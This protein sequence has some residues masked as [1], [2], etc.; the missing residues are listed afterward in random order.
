MPL[1][2]YLG[3]VVYWLVGGESKLLKKSLEHERKGEQSY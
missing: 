2:D 1:E 3:H